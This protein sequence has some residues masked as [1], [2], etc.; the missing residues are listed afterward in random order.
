M[1]ALQQQAPHFGWK[2]LM[3]YVVAC[4]SFCVGIRSVAHRCQIS[5]AG[6]VWER[7]GVDRIGREDWNRLQAMMSSSAGYAATHAPHQLFQLTCYSRDETRL[8]PRAAAMSLPGDSQRWR[9]ASGGDWA[10]AGSTQI[11]CRSAA[12]NGACAAGRADLTPC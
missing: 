2:C 5:A 3:Q 7:R 8:G 11:A 1:R 6:S 4:S 10:L 12:G 9:W